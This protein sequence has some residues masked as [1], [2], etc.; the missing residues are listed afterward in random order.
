[1]EVIHKLLK[2]REGVGA[3]KLNRV[4][5]TREKTSEESFLRCKWKKNDRS[6]SRHF[7]NTKSKTVQKGRIGGCGAVLIGG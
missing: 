5:K 6:V 1:M 4:S 2:L 7:D 3:P